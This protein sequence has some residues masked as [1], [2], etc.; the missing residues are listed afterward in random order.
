MNRG[1]QPQ[2]SLQQEVERIVGCFLEVFNRL[3][4]LKDRLVNRML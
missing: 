1:P 2:P 4:Q 3:N